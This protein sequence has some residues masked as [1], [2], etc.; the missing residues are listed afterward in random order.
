M[1]GQGEELGLGPSTAP[2]TKSGDDGGVE[3]EGGSGGGLS[4]MAPLASFHVHD[5]SLPT[6]TLW[7]NDQTWLDSTNSEP[8]HPLC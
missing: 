3:V 1:Q 2:Q 7:H 4:G 6:S 5:P 8:G